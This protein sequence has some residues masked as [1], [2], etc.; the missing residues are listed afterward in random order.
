MGLTSSILGV[1]SSEYSCRQL[2]DIDWPILP[3]P[4]LSHTPASLL[5]PA[6]ENA[7]EPL[8]RNCRQPPQ[9]AQECAGYGTVGVGIA[10]VTHG[11]YNTLLEAWRME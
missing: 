3:R 11:V 10:S 2:Q 9:C 6:V 1:P 5:W 4:G 7:I 8:P